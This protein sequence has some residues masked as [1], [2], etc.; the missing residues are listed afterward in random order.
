METYSSFVGRYTLQIHVIYLLTRKGGEHKP[1]KYIGSKTECTVVDVFGEKK[2]Y[3]ERTGKFYYSSCIQDR[4]LKDL[5]DYGFTVEILETVKLRDNV[6]E[7]EEFYQRQHDVLNSEDFYNMSYASTLN[8]DNAKESW[9]KV[10]NSLGETLAEFTVNSSRVSRLDAKSQKEGFSNFS[11]KWLE[12][13][14]LK[15]LGKNFK[16]IDG[17]LGLSKHY[18]NRFYKTF[19]KVED[20]FP[21]NVSLRLD[22]MKF[23]LEGGSL[24]KACELLGISLVYGRYLLKDSLEE[25]ITLS[26]LA[27]LNGFTSR[28]DYEIAIFKEYWLRG[29]GK[30]R[31][32]SDQFKTSTNT[33][34]R[35]IHKQITK[36][37]DI[38][39]IK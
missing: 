16:E 24:V 6:L 9:D 4:F 1:N 10:I 15:D 31:E 36:R 17:I 32:I 27:I 35:I 5:T 37:L 38:N 21:E 20:T 33:I 30:M 28:E 23:L 34:Q 25:D 39:E 22:I 2:I 11:L 8:F 12:V 13:K 7:R 19:G 14:R 29:F 18:S 26:K 3:S